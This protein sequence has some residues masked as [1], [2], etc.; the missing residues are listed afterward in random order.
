MKRLSQIFQPIITIPKN[1]KIKNTDITSKSQK[2]STIYV[3]FIY[4]YLSLFFML[5]GT[6]RL[7]FQTFLIG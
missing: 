2:V 6:C 5:N 4:C 1:A 3:C 7:L